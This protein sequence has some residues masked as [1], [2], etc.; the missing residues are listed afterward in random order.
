MARTG[1]IRRV[2]AETDIS[3]S[4]DLDGTGTTDVDAGNRF[5]N[6]LLVSLARHSTIDMKVSAKSLDGILHHLVED[7][8]ITLGSAIRDALGERSGITRFGHAT[9]PMDESLAEVSVDL[10][11]RPYRVVDL[12]LDREET[13]GVPREDIE[14][15]FDSLLHN[16]EACVHVRVAYGQNDHHKIE[17]AIKALAVSLRTA[18]APDSRRAGIPSTKGTM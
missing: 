12:S 5:I 4:V 10:V 3:V 7:T 8:A 9:V 17:A 15:F 18:M 14:H 16:M 2:T 13:E 1:D 11:R 6:H